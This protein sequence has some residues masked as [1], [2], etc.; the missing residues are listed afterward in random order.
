MVTCMWGISAEHTKLHHL[1][2]SID[3]HKP[4]LCIIVTHVLHG[5]YKEEAANTESSHTN[6]Q[7]SRLYFEIKPTKSLIFPTSA[8]F[9]IRKHQKQVF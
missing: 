3:H 4:Y 1:S 6:Y 8:L 7:S 9:S 2:T 5:T